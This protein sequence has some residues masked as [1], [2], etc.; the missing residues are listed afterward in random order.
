MKNNNKKDINIIFNDVIKMVEDG[1]L[2]SKALNKMNIDRSWFYKKITPKQKSL[3]DIA[4]VS[5]TV[6][7]VGYTYR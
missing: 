4:K 6:Y 2:I 7:G 5:H 3:L 1:Y